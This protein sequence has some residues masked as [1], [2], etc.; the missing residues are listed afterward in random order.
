V[1]SLHCTIS[2]H[3]IVFISTIQQTHVNNPLCTL[4][5]TDKVGRGPAT[6]GN[7]DSRYI[8]WARKEVDKNKKKKKRGG[9]HCRGA[10][11]AKWNFDDAVLLTPAMR[12]ALVVISMNHFILLQSAAYFDELIGLPNQQIDLD[13][14][15][16]RHLDN[17]EIPRIP[18]T[19]TESNCNVKSATLANTAARVVGEPAAPLLAAPPLLPAVRIIEI[20]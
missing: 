16:Y 7:S 8:L 17:E 9:C 2:E 18:A 15:R 13:N 4:N 3:T 19:K 14:S 11:V 20:A 5:H 6:D 10:S 12:C 1:I